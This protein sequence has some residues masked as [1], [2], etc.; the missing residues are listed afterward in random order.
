[1]CTRSIGTSIAMVCIFCLIAQSDEI[2]SSV[3]KKPKKY[4]KY[5]NT[6][7][8]LE[9]YLKKNRTLQPILPTYLRTC[10]NYRPIETNGCL[11]DGVGLWG[12]PERNKVKLSEDNFPMYQYT[13]GAYFARHANGC[14][15]MYVQLIVDGKEFRRFYNELDVED[16]NIYMSE[17]GWFKRSYY[18][19]IF[20]VRLYKFPG[21]QLLNQQKFIMPKDECEMEAMW[22]AI[23]YWREHKATKEGKNCPLFSSNMMIVLGEEFCNH[24]LKEDKQNIARINTTMRKYLKWVDCKVYFNTEEISN[25]YKN[26]EELSSLY[27]YWVPITIFCVIIIVAGL[28]SQ[29]YRKKFSNSYTFTQ[30]IPTQETFPQ[31]QDTFSRLDCSSV[32]LLHRPGC[33]ILDQVV[34]DLLQILSCYDITIECPLLE[35]SHIDAQGGLQNV[36]RNNVE[37][38]SVILLFITETVEEPHMNHKSFNCTLSLLEG[39]LKKTSRVVPIYL[40]DLKDI[41][42]EFPRFLISAH[43]VGY[44]IPNQ[45]KD[46]TE[47]LKGKYFQQSKE[48]KKSVEFTINRLKNQIKRYCKETHKDCCKERCLQGQLTEDKSE[49]WSASSAVTSKRLEN[50]NNPNGLPCPG[51]LPTT[52]SV[53]DSPLINKR[54]EEWME[55]RLET[56]ES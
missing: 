13:Y 32:L 51:L 4:P 17:F 47:F 36:I 37:K 19:K 55:N 22:S 25:E 23:D 14:S 28:V 20:E 41:Q 3:V 52:Q 42:K 18:G 48:G 34:R 40:D 26:R 9:E 50:L 43:N 16:Y 5:C 12:F 44:K 27:V 30:T 53:L 15:M 11:I 33:D 6:T 10:Y 54:I 49:L 31:I 1:M 29:K 35:M 24:A 8:L 2:E 7:Y 21:G 45:L 46:L 38:C 56:V 39:N